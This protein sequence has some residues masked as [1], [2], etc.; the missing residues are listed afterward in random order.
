MDIQPENDRVGGTT[1]V[2]PPRERADSP[3]EEVAVPADDLFG[4]PMEG[5]AGRPGEGGRIEALE[6]RPEVVAAIQDDTTVP[7]LGG[8]EASARF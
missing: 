2:A 5:T 6:D 1:G 3:A 7:G 4:D 8:D